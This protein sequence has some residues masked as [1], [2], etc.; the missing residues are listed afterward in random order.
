MVHHV[1]IVVVVC[2]GAVICCGIDVCMLVLLCSFAPADVAIVVVAVVEV[3]S[4]KEKR[5][6]VAVRSL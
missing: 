6:S 2:R 5:S 1:A 3:G 4:K